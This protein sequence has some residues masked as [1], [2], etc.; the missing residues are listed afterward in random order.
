VKVDKDY[1]FDEHEMIDGELAA[2]VEQIGQGH[3]AAGRANG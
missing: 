1:R 3:L 2:S